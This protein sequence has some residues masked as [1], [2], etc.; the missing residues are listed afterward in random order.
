MILKQNTFI[1]IIKN[2]KR[3]IDKSGYFSKKNNKT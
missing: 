2:S 3:I 1:T